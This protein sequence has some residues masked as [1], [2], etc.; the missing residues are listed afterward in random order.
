VGARSAEQLRQSVGWLDQP[1]PSA[2][3]AELKAKGLLREDAPTQ[4]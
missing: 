3:W 4:T 1:I 2:F